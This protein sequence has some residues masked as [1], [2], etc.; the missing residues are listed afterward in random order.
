MEYLCHMEV[1]S[2]LAARV[3]RLVSSPDY[4][5]SKPKQIALQLDVDPDDYRE[6]KRVVKALVHQGQLPGD[7]DGGS[8]GQR[9]RSQRR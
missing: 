8:N 9:R 5:P 1:S 7:A 4:R 3:L 2:A 6:V